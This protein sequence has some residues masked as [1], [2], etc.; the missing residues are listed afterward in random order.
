MAP[1]QKKKP[2]NEE[3]ILSFRYFC[4]VYSY[5]K[6]VT[7]SVA[8]IFMKYYPYSPKLRNLQYNKHS[9]N[10]LNCSL[11]NGKYDEM[12]IESKKDKKW[13]A[14]MDQAF[15]NHQIIQEMKK[16]KQKVPYSNISILTSF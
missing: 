9:I 4:E 1:P 14:D 5:K 12:F 16:F 2:L 13:I 6:E 8:I 15:K 3:M 7:K 10:R 11:R